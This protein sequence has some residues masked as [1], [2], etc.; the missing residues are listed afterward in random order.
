MEKTDE[1][2]GKTQ[3]QRV[4][5]IKIIIYE[6]KNKRNVYNWEEKKL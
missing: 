4:K 3:N 2:R 1:T 6:E 5:R